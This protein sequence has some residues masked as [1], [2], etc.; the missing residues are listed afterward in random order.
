M[1]HIGKRIAKAREGGADYIYYRIVY[2]SGVGKL[3]GYSDGTGFRTIG[4]VTAE[5]L[6]DTDIALT[7]NTADMGLL[8]DQLE[9][10]ERKERQDVPPGAFSDGSGGG[11]DR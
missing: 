6:S 1:A 11:G 10:L 9:K 5:N 4:E 2:Q 8:L 7:V 3:Q